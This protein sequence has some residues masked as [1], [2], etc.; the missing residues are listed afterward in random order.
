MF[1]LQPFKDFCEHVG[2]S[3]FKYEENPRQ[4]DVTFTW[5]GDFFWG[6]NKLGGW[7]IFSQDSKSIETLQATWERALQQMI[8][9]RDEQN[10][11]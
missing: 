5:L 9:E 3:E 1:L 10:D 8:K 6:Y 11:G 2:Q 7:E 4:P